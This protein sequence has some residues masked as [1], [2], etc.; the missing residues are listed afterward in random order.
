M[1]LNSEDWHHVAER[2]TERQICVQSE[3]REYSEE[4]LDLPLM[5]GIEMAQGMEAAE[6]NA[7]NLQNGEVSGEKS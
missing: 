5:R 6:Q 2:S 7:E 1:P 3:G 4:T